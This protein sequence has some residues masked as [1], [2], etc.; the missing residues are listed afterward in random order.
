MADAGFRFSNQT[1]ICGLC[2]R[3]KV[4]LI[5]LGKGS[6]KNAEDPFGQCRRLR[7]S[8]NIK[9]LCKNHI[10]RLWLNLK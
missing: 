3:D 1:D 6:L 4:Y 10:I 2:L 9:E 5:T 7:G 8:R